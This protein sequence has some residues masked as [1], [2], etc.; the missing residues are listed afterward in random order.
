M[1]LGLW[2][3]Q[4]VDLN[5]N[6]N[7]LCCFQFSYSPKINPKSLHSEYILMTQYMINATNISKCNILPRKGVNYQRWARYSKQ[8]PYYKIM[9]LV[10]I[11]ILL[12]DAVG[13][14]KEYL[15]QALS[16]SMCNSSHS[17]VSAIDILYTLL[18]AP[19]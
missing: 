16:F 13:R 19:R 17:L 10:K 2:P 15:I 8:L 5:S 7:T 11:S 9:L 6:H 1:H 3:R 12:Q 18:L 4:N 14:K